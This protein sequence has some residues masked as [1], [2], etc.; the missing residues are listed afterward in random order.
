[1]LRNYRWLRP[2]GV[3]IISLS[4]GA[5]SVACTDSA[6]DA[7]TTAPHDD[8]HTHGDTVEAPEGLAVS[9]EVTPDALSG[10]N[11]RVLTEGFTWAPE[12]VN[13]DHAPGE[14]HAHVYVDEVKVAR[15]YGPYL[16]LGDL[17]PGRRTIRVTLNGNDHSEYARQGEAVAATVQVD[18]PAPSTGHAHDPLPAPGGMSVTIEVEPDPVGGANL[19]VATQAFTWAPEHV[20]QEEPVPGEGH[21]HVYVDGEKVGRLYGPDAHLALSPGDHQVRV[22]L[23]ANDHAEYQGMEATARVTIP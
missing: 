8:G 18:V 20:N 23:N 13:G 1:M 7:G 19:H 5:A 12:H 11:L 6:A 17:R 3:A 14:G 15:I 4:I 16:H 2:L 22:T 21:A 10:V 9:L